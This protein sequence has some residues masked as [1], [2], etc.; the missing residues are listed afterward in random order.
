[1]KTLYEIKTSRK[2]PGWELQ[3]Y[4][5]RT[6][7]GKPGPLKSKKKEENVVSYVNYVMPGKHYFYFN[8]QDKFVFLSPRYDIVRF[9]QTNVFLNLI[10]VK[11]RTADL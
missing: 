10:K 5:K 2:Y 1:M 6:L 3:D 8:Y 7:S 9:K 11:E 4:I